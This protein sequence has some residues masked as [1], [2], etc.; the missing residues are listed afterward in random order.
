MIRAARLAVLLSVCC[1][2]V[3]RAAMP[4]AATFVAEVVAQR[5]DPAT[6]DFA[7][8][9]FWELDEN[10]RSEWNWSLIKAGSNPVGM[11]STA[12]SPAVLDP[13][14]SCDIAAQLRYSAMAWAAAATKA[15]DAAE[16]KLARADL[17]RQRAKLDAQLDSAA[18]SAH[19][20]SNPP[21]VAELLQRAARDRALHEALI[22]ENWSAG[23]TRPAEFAWHLVI[24]T[25]MLAVVCDNSDWLKAQV[26][27]SGW[28]DARSFGRAA[29]EAAWQLLM[30]AD[31]DLEFQR[32]ALAMLRQLPSGATSQ[33]QLAHLDDQLALLENRKQRFGTRR[34]CIHDGSSTLFPDVEDPAHLNQR[35]ARMGLDP[36]DPAPLPRDP[37]CPHPGY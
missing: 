12:L 9:G 15:E 36:I 29:D 17:L 4:D 10:Q 31:R 35:R 2:G 6:F 13:A 8:A 37:N 14:A 5:I 33:R 26:A 27:K 24:R 1:A 7:R 16:W 28:F 20:A 3:A 34:L 18:A 19:G 32:A 30:R 21:R 11:D 25:R 23:M 22:D